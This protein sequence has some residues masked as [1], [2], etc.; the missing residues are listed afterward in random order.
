MAGNLHINRGGIIL[1]MLFLQ[2]FNYTGAA[3]LQKYSIHIFLNAFNPGL[4]F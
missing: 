1:S 3:T 2:T 4:Y